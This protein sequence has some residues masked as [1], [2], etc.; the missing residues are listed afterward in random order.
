MISADEAV[1]LVYFAG[2]DV[3][4]LHMGLFQAEALEKPDQMIFDLD[5]SDDD[6]EKVRKTAFALKD[7]MDKQEITTFVKTT[8][9]HG[10]HIHVPLKPKNNFDTVKET[11]RK[12]AEKL[13]ETCP[14][15]T[16]L[17][18]RKN[19]H[20]NKVFIDYLHNDYGMTTIAPYSPRAHKGAPLATPIGWEEL[21]DKLKDNKLGPQTYRIDNILRRLS[22]KSDPWENF[23]RQR[24]RPFTA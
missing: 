7:L 10:L 12:I 1:D 6:F 21:K 22:Q 11:A 15:L 13:N 19:K 24:R 3:I 9:S 8:E 17:E 14:E 4:E 16:T 2:Q 23:N 20:G 18:Q 5:P